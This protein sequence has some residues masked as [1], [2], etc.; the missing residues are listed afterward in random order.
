MK[1]DVI[2]EVVGSYN[3]FNKSNCCS[4]GVVSDDEQ[5][6]EVF[7]S[8][9]CHYSLPLVKS[10]KYD[11]LITSY[12][13]KSEIDFEFFEFMKN[14]LYQRWSSFILLERTEESQ[15][16][17]R[18]TNLS[19]IPAN[20]VFNLCI[21]SRIIVERPN[22]L[23]VWKE[24]VTLGVNEALAFA[25]CRCT[26]TD[27]NENLLD[28]KMLYIGD[29]YEH[30][31]FF[32]SVGLTNLIKNDLV[33]LHVNFKAQPTQ[34]TGT[35]IIWGESRDLKSAVSKTLREFCSSWHKKLKLK[36]IP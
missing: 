12:P 13:A 5:H 36:E 9:V 23:K 33:N 22:Y 20:V 35:N 15:Y 21:S 30:W 7:L 10:D 2:S 24:L 3:S 18:V 25:L 26:L 27:N 28:K 32:I 16:Y 6:E 34:C 8:R 17:I 19:K 14:V 1:S 4:F 29:D 31:P 11:Q